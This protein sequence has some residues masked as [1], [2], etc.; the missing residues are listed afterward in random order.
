MKVAFHPDVYKQLQRLPRPAFV[1]A[2]NA[3]IALAQDPR[4]A[5]VKKLAGSGSDWRIRV[6]E[7]RILYEIHDSANTLTV[8]RVAHRRE[9]Y[10]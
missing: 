6:G 9:A 2:L 3:V 5:G 1:G 7:Y 8:L 10:R 4:P